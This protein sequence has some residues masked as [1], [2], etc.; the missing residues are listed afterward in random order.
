MEKKKIVFAGSVATRSGYGARARDIARALIANDNYDVKIVPLRWG[1]TPHDALDGDDPVDQQIISRMVP[2]KIPEQPDIFIHLTIPNEFQKVGKYNIGITAGIETTMCRAEWLEGCNRMDLVL[3]SSTHSKKVFETTKYEKKEAST[4]RVTEILG[5]TRPLEVLF[6]GVQTS[7]Y[8]NRPSPST[9][10]HKQLSSIKAPFCFLFVGHWLQGDLGHDRKDVGML[11]KTFLDTFKHKS[12]KNQP[13]LILKTGLV[14][15]SEPE[16]QTIE[17]RIQDIRNLAR[18]DGYSGPLPEVYLLYGNLSDAEMNAVYNHPKVKSMVSFT[19]G[20]GF[21]R[22]LLEFT[23]TGKPV[24]ASNWSG[25]VDFLHPQYSVLLPGAMEA[26]HPSAANDWIIKDAGWFRVN[27]DTAGKL[28]MNV[29]ERHDRYMELS[30]KHRK[31]TIDNFSIEKMA[32]KMYEYID[33]IDKY[34]GMTMA[35]PVPQQ[36]EFQLPKLRK[37]DEPEQLSLPKLRKV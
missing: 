33:S 8:T 15:F 19:H 26:V 13:A 18:G 5:C 2:G 4:G 21:G 31:Y 36:K 37:I 17:K 25:P 24:I 1:N 3:T 10:V 32:E 11:V 27:Y 30:R 14:G 6:E 29:Y 22:P 7:V 23:M 35:A 9:D 20:E 34:A 16:R 28:M 12:R